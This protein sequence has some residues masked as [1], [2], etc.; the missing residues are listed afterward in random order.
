VT[1]RFPFPVLVSRFTK[2]LRH[3]LI[4]PFLSLEEGIQVPE[5][6]PGLRAMDD[7]V[8]VGARDRDDLRAGDLANRPR[9]DDRAL[10]LHEARYG[11]DGAEGAGIGQLDS[12]ARK[13]VGHQAVGPRLLDQRLVRRVESGE[14]HRFGVLD[15]GHDQRPAAVLLLDVHRE[16]EANGA[17]IDAVGF[18][19]D[20]L[21]VVR[22][23]REALGSL[24]DSVPDQVRER[25]L[26]TTRGELGVERF[27]PRVEGGCLDVAEGGRRGDG[28]RLGHVRD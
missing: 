13:V 20:V 9:G 27:A 28:Q 15:D 25:H 10:A 26:L 7:P 17:R 22:H 8:I 14:I 5:K 3:S 19:V 11:R 4:K 1:P 24:D 18:A 12:A 16:P 21:E 23:D 2:A 6:H